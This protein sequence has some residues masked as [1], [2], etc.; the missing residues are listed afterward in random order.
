MICGFIN[1]DYN[2]EYKELIKSEVEQLCLK[3]ELFSINMNNEY[4]LF[5]NKEIYKE[6]NMNDILPVIATAGKELFLRNK[7]NR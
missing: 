5:I 2:V 4:T 1:K 3:D 7:E 6:E